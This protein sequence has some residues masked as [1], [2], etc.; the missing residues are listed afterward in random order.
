MK[1]FKL[2]FLIVLLF[3]GL[4]SVLHGQ[5]QERF[6]IVGY[7][8]PKG[9]DVKRGSDAVQFTKSDEASGAFC[10]ITLVKSLPAGGDSKLN[11]HTAWDTLVADSLKVT[12]KPQMGAT[13]AKD[14]WAAEMGVA[15]FEMQGM[16][17]AAMLTTL[18]GSGRMV[19]VLVLTNSEGFEKEIEAFVDAIA[20]PA[21]AADRGDAASPAAPS[22]DF[23]RL[24]GKWNRSGSVHPTYADPVSWGLAGYTKSRYEFKTDGTYVFTERSFRMSHQRILL[25]KESGRFSVSGDEI[26]I[27]PAKSVIE[28]YS[29]KN[30]ADELGSLIETTKRQLETATYKFKFH[31]FEGIQE[32]NLVLQANAPTDRDGQFSSNT[33]FPNAWY[34]DQ[35]YTEQVL[36]AP[37][38]H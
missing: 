16:K 14:G 9:W 23:A 27:V 24:I 20:L 15:P 32:W 17:G 31:Y 18:S 1:T 10:L 37:R 36:T 4:S 12:A 35:K 7:T 29:K 28:S 34:F 3:A 5:V 13:G 6:D 38:V 25:V 8:A 2:S 30:G 33:T 21:V 19:S 22:G 11:F 26:T